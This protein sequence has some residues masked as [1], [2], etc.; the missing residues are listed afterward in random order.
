MEANLKKVIADL[1][2]SRGIADG[3]TGGNATGSAAGVMDANANPISKVS[4]P[5]V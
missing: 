2:K 3:G 4:A 5:P 1:N